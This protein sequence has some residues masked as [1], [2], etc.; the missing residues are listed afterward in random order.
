MSRKIA[1][2]TGNRAEYG[3]LLPVIKEISNRNHLELMLLVSGAH[4]DPLFGRTI[5]S[6][7]ANGFSVSAE[8]AVD[9]KSDDLYST[10]IAI[11]EGIQAIA[12]ALKKL[13]PDFLIVYAD[14][15]EGFA[16][17]VAASQMRIPVAHIEGGD[18]TDGGALDDNVRHAMTKLSHLHFTTNQ[19]AADN[20]LQL[21]EEDWRVFNAGLPS[22][23]AILQGKLA[24]KSEIATKWSIDFNAP[25]IL[26]TQHSVTT[27]FDQSA[28]HIEASLNALEHFLHKGAQVF[29]T[30]PNNDAGGKLIIESINT[31]QQHLPSATQ[32]RLFVV[33]ALGSYFYHGLLALSK[34]PL[35]RLVCV[36]NSSSGIKE[37]PVFGCP[38]VNIGSR[39]D[40][41]LR[42]GN[43]L[44]VPYD[45][46]SILTAIT[47]CLDDSAFRKHCAAVDNPYGSGNAAKAIVDVL[48]SM[49]LDNRLIAKKTIFYR[50][51]T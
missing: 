38:T 36:G 30:Y 31:W 41:R 13:K 26:F 4:L 43:V 11:G 3:L 22:L 25:I 37:T 8:I 15:F 5:D 20:V 2:F 7:K 12:S 18:M 45:M 39:Q 23:D 42:A 33:P 27:Q 50:G 34:D 46:Q 24:S 9:L 19:Q 14:R 16:A 1:V 17:V 51:K 10:A 21:G 40:G 44:D 32:K 35:V 29:V 48:Q 6:I 28:I 47:Q 49:P